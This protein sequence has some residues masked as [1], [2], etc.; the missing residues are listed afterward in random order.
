MCD[1]GVPWKNICPSDDKYCTPSTTNVK[2]I[3]NTLTIGAKC[4]EEGVTVKTLIHELGH[5][6]GLYHEMNRGDRDK[7]IEILDGRL[8]KVYARVCVHVSVCVDVC[9]FVCVCV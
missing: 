1:E 4:E 8:Q 3:G 7:Y 2:C 6:L 9:V 5:V